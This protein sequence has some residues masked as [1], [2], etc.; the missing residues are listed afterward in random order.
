MGKLGVLAAGVLTTVVL[1]GCAAPRIDNTKFTRPKTVVIADFPD[2]K[3]AATISVMVAKWPHV[4][5]APVM[6]RFFVQD[7][8]TV[9][10]V[11]TDNS[12]LEIG[13]AAGTVA[14][15]QQ[16]SARNSNTIQGGIAGGIVGGI[17]GGIIEANAAATEKQAAEFPGLVRK[18]LPG[19][20]MRAD[21]LN[22]LRASLEAKGISVKIATESR[23]KVPRLHWPAKDEKGEA[24]GIDV[25]TLAD[26][27]AVNADLFVQVSPMAIYAAPGP[28]NNY[29][30]VVGIGLA[31]YDGRKREF[32]GWQGFP[33]KENEY[34]YARYTSLA[35]D[36]DK[37]AAALHR[38]LLALVPSV[39]DAI[40]GDQK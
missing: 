40:S 13:V 37:V 31:M 21:L 22:A 17:V 6:D 12:N 14:G 10:P 32:I 23:N 39:S 33:A 11:R 4:Y 8:L 5:F 7:E 36:V 19:K 29:N 26:N 15:I 2:M 18:A 20:D 3:N 9:S 25:G 34:S 30:S 35:A 16:A 24:L 28:L 27:P 38:D 1:T